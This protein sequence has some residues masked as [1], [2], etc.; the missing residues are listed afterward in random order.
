MTDRDTLY[1]GV[2]KA[3]WAYLFLYF[4]INLGTVSILP[5]FVGRCLFVSAIRLLSG[6]RRDLKLLEGFAIGLTLWDLANWLLSWAGLSLDDLWLPLSLLISLTNLYFHF[7][8]LTDMA[9]LAADWQPAD[10]ELDKRLLKWRTLQTLML[11]ATLLLSQLMPLL[12]EWS[13]VVSLVTMLIYL[14]ATICLMR[15]LFHLRKCFL[16]TLDPDTPPFQ[17]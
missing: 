13:G 5:D 6:E 3:A 1:R 2:S 17:P 11:T 14:I 8:F 7:Q 16:P 10:R 4:D 15:T 9:A 12:G